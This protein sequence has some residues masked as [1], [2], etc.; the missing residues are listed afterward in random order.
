MW[1]AEQLRLKRNGMLLTSE[2]NMLPFNGFGR[3]SINFV[4]ENAPTAESS[5]LFVGG[6]VRTNEQALLASM[7]VLWMREH[8]L[9]AREIGEAIPEWDDEIVYQTARKIVNAEYQVTTVRARAPPTLFT[10]PRTQ[11]IVYNEWL[12][13][14]IGSGT[15]PAYSGFK[16][17]VDP[18]ISSL[19]STAA[20]R[21]GHS[22]VPQDIKRVGPDNLE[23]ETMRLKDTFFSPSLLLKSG[24]M[25]EELLR[26]FIRQCAMK[27]DAKVVDDLRNFLFDGVENAGGVDLA[28]ANIQRGREMGLPSYMQT[29]KLLGL[30]TPAHDFT[31]ITK[32]TETRRRLQT[33]YDRDVEKVDLWV[34]GISEDPAQG[35]LV[36]ETFSEIIRDQFVRLRDGDRFYYELLEFPDELKERYSRIEFIMSKPMTMRDIIFRNTDILADTFKRTNPFRA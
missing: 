14:L 36:G 15:I 19:F 18:S 31:T 26:G 7:Q 33:A 8:N 13:L 20:F 35:S 29:R 28:T 34:G 23:I 17:D 4:A 10:L 2:G 32:N 27:L 5:T 25:I 24:T 3:D 16:E 12:P 11:N 9:V 21:F 6:E 1:R 30:S 22:M